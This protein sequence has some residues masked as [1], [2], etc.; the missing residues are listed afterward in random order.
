[1]TL[2]LI[3][4]VFFKWFID[5]QYISLQPSWIFLFFPPRWPGTYFLCV[6]DKIPFAANISLIDT[7]CNAHKSEIC[8]GGVA[9]RSHSLDSEVWWAETDC[10]VEQRQKK[11]ELNLLTESISGLNE[12]KGT[13]GW[14]RGLSVH[15]FSL[16]WISPQNPER[17]NKQTQTATVDIRRYRF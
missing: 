16:L 10:T 12:L 11:K 8:S 9:G 13:R 5:L 7:L 4:S 14:R 1:M 17:N 3:T 6:G 15:A 2:S